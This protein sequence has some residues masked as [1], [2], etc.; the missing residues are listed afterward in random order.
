MD[1]IRISPERLTPDRVVQGRLTPDRVQQDRQSPERESLTGQPGIDRARRMSP[2][3][4]TALMEA[5]ADLAPDPRIENERTV[6]ENLARQT[7]AIN[8]LASRTSTS[9]NPAIIGYAAQLSNQVNLEGSMP[10]H[11]P[12]RSQYGD[13]FGDRDRT[14]GH[15]R[16][17]PT[18][19]TRGGPAVL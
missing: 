10:P 16:V 13:R 5:A 1:E 2:D 15:V 19:E 14:D 17:P 12:L 8:V 3:F 18:N 11:H 6:L 9:F 7:A 4:A